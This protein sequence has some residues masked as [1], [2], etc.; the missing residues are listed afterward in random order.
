MLRPSTSL[1]LRLFELFERV[2]F[3]V[4]KCIRCRRDVGDYILPKKNVCPTCQCPAILTSHLVNKPYILFNQPCLLVWLATWAG[5][6][7]QIARCDWLPELWTT[8]RVPREKIPES[9]IINPLLTKL[10]RS[11]WLD[12]GLIFFCEFM[13]RLGPSW[14]TQK[15]D[16]ANI[17]LS[18]PHSRL[19]SGT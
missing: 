18:W 15:K 14:N 10:F 16:E 17:Q 3:A 11:R 2:I 5:K 6:M 4:Y 9:Q 12:I 13:D 1:G 19:I 7:N 8:R